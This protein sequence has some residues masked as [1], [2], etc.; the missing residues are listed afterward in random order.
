MDESRLERKELT[1]DSLLIALYFCEQ[2]AIESY[3]TAAVYINTHRFISTDST[4]ILPRVNS[5]SHLML[6]PGWLAKSLYLSLISASARQPKLCHSLASFISNHH[7]YLPNSHLT[8]SRLYH[9]GSLRRPRA[10]Q[11][12]I[13]IRPRLRIRARSRSSISNHSSEQE[14]RREEGVELYSRREDCGE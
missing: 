14:T 7:F 6:L 9:N 12:K 10:L 8:L 3:D 1:E 11:L 5:I 2:G 4:I 13:R